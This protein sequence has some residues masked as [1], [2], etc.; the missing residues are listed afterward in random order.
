[1]LKDRDG[2]PNTHYADAVRLLMSDGKEQLFVNA[3]D[4][5]E[6]VPATVS[7]ADVDF[8]A[9]YM[10]ITPDEGT[11]LSKV[12]VEKPANLLAEYIK[13][14]INIAGI[15][16]ELAGGGS[17]KIA[18]NWAFYNAQSSSG[19]VTHGLGVVPDIVIVWGYSITANVTNKVKFY[20][21]CSSAFGSK[22]SGMGGSAHKVVVYN[23]ASTTVTA[24]FN[25]T[26]IDDAQNT[27]CIFGATDTIFKLEASSS[28][29]LD[30]SYQWVAIGGLT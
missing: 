4:V 3:D 29:K 20:Q 12:T 6:P 2:T 17:A 27:N 5:P 24:K 21:G 16:G 22:Y 7:A 19:T 25:A 9:G 15:V 10:E 14:G 13:E 1:M 8:T 18:T 23:T 11:V 26:G 28:Y 30:G